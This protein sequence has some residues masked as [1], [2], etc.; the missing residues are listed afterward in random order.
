[1]VRLHD[2]D[3]LLLFHH[4]LPPEGL[5]VRLASAGPFFM[6]L[7]RIHPARTSSSFSWR[8]VALTLL[9]VASPAACRPGATV[10]TVP[11]PPDAKPMAAA[12]A[13]RIEAIQEAPSDDSVRV[14]DDPE[15]RATQAA[16]VMV[17][18]GLRVDRT[19]G[20]VEVDGVISLDAGLLEQVVCARG[21]REH[22]SIFV[23]GAKPSEIHAA[24]LL[25]GFEPGRPGLWRE[26][27]DGGLEL[28]PPTGDP[29]EVLLR[30]ESGDRP[31]E[32]AQARPADFRPISMFI[33]DARTGRPFPDRPFVF[34][35]SLFA[36]NPPSLGPGEHYVA[37]WT[38]SIVG[39][40]TFGDEVVAWEEVIPDR[41]EVAEPV[42]EANP[43]RLPPPGAP[44]TLLLRR[45]EASSR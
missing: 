1:M 21:T 44:A 6:R 5:G 22:E 19:R 28:V 20:T 34:A 17:K 2:G 30:V 26:R 15:A 10:E 24:L 13:S 18:P 3:R 8:R 29:I 9:L 27:P 11:R 33:R 12:P 16:I 25:A 40:V 23:P 7:R 39:L 32:D 36:P 42:W 4:P 37:D 14:P 35:G 38:G 45:P 41:A 43:L 31:A